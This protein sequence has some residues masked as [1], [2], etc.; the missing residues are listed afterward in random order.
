MKFLTQLQELW[1]GQ[2]RPC[3][4]HDLEL[5]QQQD[6]AR[7]ISDLMLRASFM[8]AHTLAE[9]SMELYL[10]EG[11]GI[12]IPRDFAN[13][14]TEE[15]WS[16]QSDQVRQ[17]LD[18]VRLGPDQEHYWDEWLVVEQNFSMLRDDVEL[19]LYQNGDLWLV[20]TT[21]LLLAPEEVVEQMWDRMS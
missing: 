20:N 8:D 17:A 16:S 5:E 7:S 11:R 9:H 4:W 12:F 18:Y 6:F 21:M 1:S 2:N 10:S 13:S 19:T 3:D 14:L 15:V